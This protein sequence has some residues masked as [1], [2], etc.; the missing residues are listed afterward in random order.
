MMSTIRPDASSE[1]R[2]EFPGALL[3]QDASSQNSGKRRV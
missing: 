1:G 3:A 2:L